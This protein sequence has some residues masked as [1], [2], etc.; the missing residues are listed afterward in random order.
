MPFNF[1]CTKLINTSLKL[2]FSGSWGTALNA[3]D[4][5]HPS[6]GYKCEKSFGGFSHGCWENL[7]QK[8]LYVKTGEQVG[9][10]PTMGLAWID[11]TNSAKVPIIHSSNRL[12]WSD[13]NPN[14]NN[15]ETAAAE[16]KEL[17]D[18]NPEGMKWVMGVP[19][20]G[21]FLVSGQNDKFYYL[22]LDVDGFWRNHTI[23]GEVLLTAVQ[24][25][26]TGTAP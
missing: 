22:S 5:S 4:D 1:F 10:A 13:P 8:T 3:G 25:K 20:E 9:D 17:S 18:S 19:G 6:Q 21:H 14:F 7:E 12:Y 11:G 15:G 16:Q 26:A 2:A 24:V 23:M